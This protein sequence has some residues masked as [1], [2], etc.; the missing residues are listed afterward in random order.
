MHRDIL[1]ETTSSQ[2]VR[3]TKVRSGDQGG[4]LLSVIDPQCYRVWNEIEIFQI[5]VK[6][7]YYALYH[8]C[9][10]L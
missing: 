5:S 9:N 7:L 2:K 4:G 3:A 10:R 6:N 1:L 8:C